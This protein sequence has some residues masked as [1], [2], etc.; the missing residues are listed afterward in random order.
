MG[1]HLAAR[2]SGDAGTPSPAAAADV[3]VRG[4]SW[5]AAPEAGLEADHASGEEV[6]TFPLHLLEVALQACL[7]R[8]RL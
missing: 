3:R 7:S 2:D 1:G 5:V 8:Y 6:A 4:A